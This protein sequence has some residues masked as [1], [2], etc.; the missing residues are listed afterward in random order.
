MGLFLFNPSFLNLQLFTFN[1]QLLPTPW[2]E[3]V[4][5]GLLEELF[6]LGGGAWSAPAFE[7]EGAEIVTGDAAFFL[8]GALKRLSSGPVVG[9]FLRQV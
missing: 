8:T 2:L 1:L 6:G 3:A 5:A 4:G 7:P 9:W